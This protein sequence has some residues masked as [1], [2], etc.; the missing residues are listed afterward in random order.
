MRGELA[1]DHH[2][3]LVAGGGRVGLVLRHAG[4]WCLASPA[5]LADLAWPAVVLYM[6]QICA[7][8]KAEGLEPGSEDREAGAALALH[9]AA[10]QA[11]RLLVDAW[12][13]VGGGARPRAD[14]QAARQQKVLVDEE[15]H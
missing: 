7:N 4:A 2:P 9:A 15:A 13:P 1:R 5:R 3:R 14:G 11:H 8:V 6:G 10:A 12:W